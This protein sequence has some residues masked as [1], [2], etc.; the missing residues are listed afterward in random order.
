MASS[1]NF[2]VYDSTTSSYK[3]LSNVLQK[4]ISGST[5]STNMYFGS[6]DIG[7]IF[8]T[9]NGSSVQADPTRLYQNSI[10]LCTLFNKYG[11]PM[12]NTLN[13]ISGFTPGVGYMSTIINGI[14]IIGF[15]NQYDYYYQDLSGIFTPLNDITN[16]VVVVVGGG[17]GG[18]DN[19][20]NGSN[21]SCGAGGGAGGNVYIATDVVFN[22]NTEYILNVGSGGQGGFSNL[23]SYRAA[24]YPS[25]LN[26][27]SS[28]GKKV[29]IHI[30]E[31]IM[32]LVVVEE[33]HHFL[34][35]H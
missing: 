1:T 20:G 31:V 27:S 34:L 22:K 26:Y 18:G 6:T 3:D 15:F 28:T 13:T 9:Y 2:F 16:A 5:R 17:G 33:E 35:L 32:H 8:Q 11:T 24:T 14:Y 23:T 10:D 25:A 21:S 7:S 29:V 30:L 12:N 4:Y 19:Y